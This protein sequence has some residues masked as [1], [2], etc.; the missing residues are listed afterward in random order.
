MSLQF[1]RSEEVCHFNFSVR[2]KYDA[3]ISPVGGSMSLQFFRLEEVLLCLFNFSGRRKYVASIFPVGES[4]TMSL[5]FFPVGGSMLLQLLIEGTF[6]S[7]LTN[8]L[9]SSV[10]KWFT[11]KVALGNVLD[12]KSQYVRTTRHLQN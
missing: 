9:G 1:F 10:C 3:S 7:M 5:Q 6:C 4:I 2:R 8:L 11:L 12:L